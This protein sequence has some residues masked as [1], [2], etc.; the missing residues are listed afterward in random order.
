MWVN[1][2]CV[3]VHIKLPFFRRNFCSRVAKVLH[4]VKKTHGGSQATWVTR[5]IYFYWRKTKICIVYAVRF[6]INNFMHLV[7]MKNKRLIKPLLVVR[8]GPGTNPK[9]GSHWTESLIAT[10]RKKKKEKEIEP[11]RWFVVPRVKFFFWENKQDELSV[12]Y[13]LEGVSNGLCKHAYSVFIFA[14]MI[15]QL[16]NFS[17]EQRPVK[18]NTNGHVLG[19]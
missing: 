1:P 3:R 18:K 14:S 7:L 17:Y 12:R 5:F 9:Y 4:C 10:W 19:L 6:P 8:V 16:S 13:I 2:A 15:M 11:K